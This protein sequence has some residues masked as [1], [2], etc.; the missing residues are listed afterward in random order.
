MTAGRSYRTNIEVLR[1]VLTAVRKPV[2]KTRI[3][4]LAN[5]N[6]RSFEEYLRFCAEHELVSLTSGR[7]VV[8]PRG[9][10]VLDAIEAVLT[11]TTELQWAVHRLKRTVS[12]RPVTEGVPGAA[13][14]HMARWAW[15]EILLNGGGDPRLRRSGGFARRGSTK[16][17][18]LLQISAETRG[19]D[20][21][22]EGDAETEEMGTATKGS[23]VGS[24][25]RRS[26]ST[27]RPGR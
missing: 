10:T 16:E 15:T 4:G 23:P 26:P 12:D 18:D 25:S 21:L 20:G 3:I 22:S 27:S 1:D 8:T 9:D 6:P 11:K 14:R 2:P 17:G 13:L 24:G 19:Q 5:L 7:Y